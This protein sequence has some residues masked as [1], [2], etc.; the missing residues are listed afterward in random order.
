MKCCRSWLERCCRS[1]LRLDTQ[2][3]MFSH[4]HG[5]RYS[6]TICINTARDCGYLFLCG[7]QYC[8]FVCAKDDAIMENNMKMEVTGKL[9]THFNTAPKHSTTTAGVS[10][11]MV[12][13]W[14]ETWFV[15]Y[16]WRGF[17][18][19]PV[20]VMRL[21]FNDLLNL[22]Q[23]YWCLGVGLVVSDPEPA[24]GWTCQALF[25]AFTAW[26]W[27]FDPNTQDCAPN[28]TKV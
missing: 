18:F 12:S 22:N 8:V 5:S 2:H 9:K 16:F 28:Q 14:N 4:I 25:Q 13:T 21:P 24:V 6:N 17:F 11:I 23:Q 26:L 20:T 27:M 15:T 19:N 7:F 10:V 3:K 1:T